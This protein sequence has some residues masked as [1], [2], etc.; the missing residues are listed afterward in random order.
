MLACESEREREQLKEIFKDK[1]G[2]KQKVTNM[3]KG[4]K[5]NSLKN[6]NEDLKFAPKRR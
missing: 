6:D 5:R 1:A 4:R 3:R 2:R